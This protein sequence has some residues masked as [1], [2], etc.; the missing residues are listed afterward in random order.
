MVICK[1]SLT[2]AFGVDMSNSMNKSRKGLIMR[3]LHKETIIMVFCCI[4]LI[5]IFVNISIWKALVLSDKVAVPV[6]LGILGLPPSKFAPEAHVFYHIMLTEDMIRTR[7]VVNEQIGYLRD[8]GVEDMLDTIHYTAIGPS[9]E[10]FELFAENHKYKKTNASN[11][12]GWEPGTLHLLHGHCK[13]RP[14]DVVLYLHTKGVYHNS[15]ENEIQR[16]DQT[17]SLANL[18]C[19]QSMREGGE[20]TGIWREIHATGVP[21]SGG[22][23]CGM[24]FSPSPHF[25]FPGNMWWA[26]CDYIHNL[27]DPIAFGPKMNR[28]QS[29]L[30]PGMWFVQNPSTLGSERFAAEHWV[31]SHPSIRALDL[32]PANAGKNGQFFSAGYKLLPDHS[33][34]WDPVPS[35]IPRNDMDVGEYLKSHYFLIM[36]QHGVHVDTRMKEYSVLYGDLAL[37]QEI[38]EYCRNTPCRLYVNMAKRAQIAID[39]KEFD[40]VTEQRVHRWLLGWRTAFPALKCPITC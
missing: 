3:L 13:K 22:D 12:Q 25:H 32:M 40:P 7:D 33:G 18:A 26:R 36:V 28:L 1:S 23:V 11:C 31:S 5:V 14:Q 21:S 15:R 4:A 37:N 39:N 8:S 29:Y 24:R 6:K 2:K 38:D 19:L 27:M 30:Y 35:L 10:K 17:K 16:Q 34:T 20:R 9:S